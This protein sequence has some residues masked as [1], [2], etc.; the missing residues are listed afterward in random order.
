MAQIDEIVSITITSETQA[1]DVASFNIPL[2]LAEFTDFTDSRTR[3]YGD[4]DE[5]A[6]DFGTDS[7]VYTMAVK[8]FGQD[9]KPATIVVGRKDPDESWADAYTA[10]KAE[11][12]TWFAMVASTHVKADVLA[13]AALVSADKKVY[14]TSTQE[15]DVL[16]NSA[17]NIGAQ[18]KALGYDQVSW[19]YGANADT[20]F[21]EAAWV[22][23][24]LTYT[25]GANTW[26]FK[27]L[28][29][30]TVDKLTTT[31]R[32]N[33][34]ANNGSYYTTVGGVNITRN[35]KMANGKWVDQ[36][37]IELWTEAR[38]Q[39]SVFGM[40]IRK[41]K[42]PMTD[43]GITLVEA[44]MRSVLSQGIDN[45]A[46]ASYVINVPRAADIPANQKAQRIA[47]DF[48]FNAVLA[49]AIHKVVIVGTVS[50]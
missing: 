30:V 17:D 33:I 3:T 32:D 45:G 47:G 8:L 50:L 23:S 42:V 48:K 39:E 5:V 34:A 43:A 38:M 41:P 22:G 19:R 21:P 6:E 24:Q 18:L 36:K 4:D 49:N 15:T 46:F 31:Q 16:T 11:N 13:L 14:F 27:Q 26:E 37:I 7:V 2:I 9:Q 25:P 29:G 1:V 40:L 28:E 10:V 35:S 44:Q 12:D 20:Q